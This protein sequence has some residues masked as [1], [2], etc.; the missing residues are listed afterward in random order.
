MS[1]HRLKVQSKV[2][3]S[4]VLVWIDGD[5]EVPRIHFSCHISVGSKIVESEAFISCG[6]AYAI[7]YIANA[8]LKCLDVRPSNTQSLI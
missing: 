7:R 3:A 5:Y 1:D 6:A 8:N 2:S 4:R